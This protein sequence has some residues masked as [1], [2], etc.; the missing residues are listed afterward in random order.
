MKSSTS[1][2]RS[3]RSWAPRRR[4]SSAKRNRPRTRHRRPR[5][6]RRRLSIARA[7]GRFSREQLLP[8]PKESVASSDPACRSCA[9]CKSRP[10]RNAQNDAEVPPV[11]A[12]AA[13]RWLHCFWLVAEE[14]ES[15]TCSNI[16]RML[17]QVRLGS[18]VACSYSSSASSVGQPEMEFAEVARAQTASAGSS[19]LAVTANR[20]TIWRSA[21]S[22]TTDLQF[23][24]WPGQHDQSASPE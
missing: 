15:C 22:A 5:G 23:A 12:E 14:L 4:D 6:R 13:L 8:C 7:V 17:N 3:K 18:A 9:R 10:C 20:T 24:C 16:E 1:S 21:K 11:F 19:I 2:A